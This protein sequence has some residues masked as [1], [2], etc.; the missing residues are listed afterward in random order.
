VRHILHAALTTQKE[1]HAAF[2]SRSDVTFSP[3]Q[4]YVLQSAR[5][6]RR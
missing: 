4:N 6:L 2:A 3:R 1:T 5:A